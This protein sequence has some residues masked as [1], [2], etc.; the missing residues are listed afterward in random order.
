MHPPAGSPA[1]RRRVHEPPSESGGRLVDPPLEAAGGATSIDAL[2]DNNRLLRAAFDTRIGDLKLWELVAA[3]RRE[4]LTVAAEYTSSYRD[5]DRPT[6]VADWI[7][8]PII[9]GGHQPDLFHPGVWLKNAALDAYARR[10]GGIVCLGRADGVPADGP[11]GRWWS[12]G[13]RSLI[14]S[15]S[16]SRRRVTCSRAG[17]AWRRSNC[18]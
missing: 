16:R 11:G 5:V 8:R 6:D 15:A 14:A 3:T 9:M 10:V 13:R 7:A 12:N 1:P 17:S 4:V 2:V 18:P